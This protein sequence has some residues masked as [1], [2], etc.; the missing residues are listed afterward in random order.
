MPSARRR[1][2]RAAPGRDNRTAVRRR[3]LRARA[4]PLQRR[5]H[6]RRDRGGVRRPAR[7]ERRTC[8]RAAAVESWSDRRAVPELPDLLL[9]TSALAR[10]RRRSAAAARAAGKPVP[11]AVGRRRR[12]RRSR[13]ARSKACGCSASGSSSRSRTTMC[14]VL[15]L[16]IAGRLHWKRGRREDPGQGRPGGVR[17]SERHADPDRSRVEAA[18]VAARR[19]RRRRAGRH[20]S[21]RHRRARAPIATPSRRCSTRESHT[22]KRALTD[23][24]LF[25]GIGNAYSDEILHAARLSPMRLTHQLDDDEIARLHA[26]THETLH[27]RGSTACAR[28]P[29]TR[30]PRR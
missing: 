6:G 2:D 17:L 23:P 13:A 25:S 24:R 16:M 28:E 27:R 12:W 1:A 3:G 9:Y 20:G 7:S 5:A 4:P 30:S 11:A 22:L 15:H 8:A 21:G 29:A 10:A 18:G 19:A 26:A 14:L